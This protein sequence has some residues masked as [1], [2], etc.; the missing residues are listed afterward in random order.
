MADRLES[1][2]ASVLVRSLDGARPVMAERSMYMNDRG[3]GTNTI[4]GFTD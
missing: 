3:A 4:G 2:R 1:G